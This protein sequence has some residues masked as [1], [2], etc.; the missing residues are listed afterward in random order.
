MVVFIDDIL[1]YSKIREEHANHLRIIIQTLEDH[2]LYAKREKCDFLMTEVKFLGHV[3]SQEEISVDLAK[4]DTILQWERP[5]NVMEIHRFL[6][7]VGYY[8]CFVKNFSRIAALLT[9]LTRKVVRFEWDDNC[10]STFIEL[11]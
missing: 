6:R 10:E 9:R 3:V 8:R 4:I 2:Q 5:K 1:V 7:L 11:K